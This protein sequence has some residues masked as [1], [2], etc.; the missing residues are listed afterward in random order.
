M[1][2]IAGPLL[3]GTDFSREADGAMQRAALLAREHA[4]PLHLIYALEDGDWLS[5]LARVTHGHFSHELLRKAAGSQLARLRDQLLADGVPS[6]ETEIVDG[7]LHRTLPGIAEEHGYGLFIMGARG[8]GS[9]RE[10]LL[11][12]TADRVLRSGALPVLLC[13]R[14][15]APW[16]R[17][18]LATDFSPASAQA[19]ALGLRIAPEASHY[20]L[21]ACELPLDR[22]LAF[23]N[24]STESRVAFHR[25]ASEQSARQLAAFADA[26]GPAGAEVTRAPREGPPAAVLSSFVR[27]ADIDLV[28]LGARP[29][30]RWEANLLGSTALFATSRLPCDVLLVPARD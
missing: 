23:A 14:E 16:Q 18:A 26:L 4:V 5:R 19:A 29:R 17:V 21:H 13:R 25:E 24:V 6:V 2:S 3:M 8:G 22:S 27:E 7:P 20:L 28:V 11:G 10:E 30:A 1:S 12:S 9:F 15:A